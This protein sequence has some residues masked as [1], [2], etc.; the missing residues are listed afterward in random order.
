MQQGIARHDVREGL[1][2][3]LGVEGTGDVVELTE[4]VET[5][6]HH[7]EF[8]FE[9]GTGE[10]GI[11]DEIVGV[12]QRVGIACAGVEAEVGR[13]IELPGQ[14]Q[15]SGESGPAGECIEVLEVDAVAGVAFPHGL[16]GELEVVLVD[17]SLEGGRE[18]EGE[19]V[20]GGRPTPAPSREGGAI[21][22]S[23]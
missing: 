16:T 1:G 6:E 19:A 22:Y 3:S 17:I 21:R 12:Q 15:D 4:N 14:F 13:E 18:G 9:E 5:V 7:K 23:Y 8:S 20:D 11:P 10:S 2:A